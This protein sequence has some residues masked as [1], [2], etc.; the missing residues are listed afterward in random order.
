MK[1]L[2]I[3]MGCISAIILMSSCTADGLESVEN[4]NSNNYNKISVSAT[5][6]IIPPPPPII[7]DRDKTK[8]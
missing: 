8:F 7:D 4:E 1:K 6:E 2:L 3:A 5:D